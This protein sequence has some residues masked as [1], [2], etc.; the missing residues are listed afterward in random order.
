MIIV[1]MWLLMPLIVDQ[2]LMSLVRCKYRTKREDQLW[3]V[4][5]LNVE[6]KSSHGYEQREK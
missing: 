4:C 2:G 1:V 5:G 6:Q 3:I